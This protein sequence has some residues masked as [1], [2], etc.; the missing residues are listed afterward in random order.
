MYGIGMRIAPIGLPMIM[1]SNMLSYL[2]IPTLSA[3]AKSVQQKN[4][5][6]IKEDI[7]NINT[8]LF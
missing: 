7:N 5:K 4:A 1:K 6:G 3:D 8:L 2:L